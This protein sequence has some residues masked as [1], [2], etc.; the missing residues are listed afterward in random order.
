MPNVS[1]I[2]VA[3]K[4]TSTTC[5]ITLSEV[6][7]K[8]RRVATMALNIVSYPLFPLADFHE[9]FLWRFSVKNRWSLYTSTT[10]LKQECLKE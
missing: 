1:G 7:K 4:Y 9:T 2:A 3:T 10:R 8:R 6:C 5:T